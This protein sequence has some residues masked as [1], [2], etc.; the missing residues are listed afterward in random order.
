[1]DISS[2]KKVL[3]DQRKELAD[4]IEGIDRDLK[5][6]RNADSGEQAVELENEEVLS[7]LVR[8]AEEELTQVS[9][10]LHRLENGQYGICLECGEKINNA[11]LNAIPYS[12]RCIDCATYE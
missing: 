3:I 12:T 7:E 2:I 1:M 5:T 8:E 6:G 11:R 10:A 4:R 9:L